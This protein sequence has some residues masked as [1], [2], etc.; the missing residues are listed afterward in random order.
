[1][2]LKRYSYNWW[3]KS[4]E[5]TFL[6]LESL[7]GS[8][9]EERWWNYKIECSSSVYITNIFFFKYKKTGVLNIERTLQ[10]NALI[11]LSKW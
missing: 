4:W 7:G 10:C 9:N 3:T 5:K 2:F 8:A 11:T 1:M 6:E